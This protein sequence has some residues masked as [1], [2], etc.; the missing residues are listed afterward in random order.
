MLPKYSV[1]KGVD[2]V[3]SLAFA[4]ELGNQCGLWSLCAAGP[5]PIW[6]TVGLSCLGLFPGCPIE[7]QRAIAEH[8]CEKYPGRIGR[9]AAAKELQAGAVDLAVGLTSGTSTRY[10]ELLASGVARDEA[11]ARVAASVAK[12]LDTWQRDGS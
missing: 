8:A 5:D 12:C 11:R 4:S 10:D 9:S 7:E 6:W 2:C 3:G 1:V